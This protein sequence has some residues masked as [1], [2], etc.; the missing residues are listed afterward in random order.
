[1][2]GIAERVYD[3][4]EET[5]EQQGVILWDVEFVK[6]GASHYLRV[7]IDKPEGVGI[8][9]C[10]AVSHAIDPV[11][12]EADPIDKSYYLEVSSPGL[13]RAL[14]R[15]WHFEQ[16]NGLPVKAKLYKA[17]EG[18]KEVKGILK[19]YDG[20]VLIETADGEVYFEKKD[21]SGVRLDDMDF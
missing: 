12:D 18:S 9:D 6:E 19:S 8:D 13:E 2:A 15:D 17:Y 4:I 11:L 14:R 10:T 20:G 7:Y 1:M 16:A 5:V 21:F 3:L